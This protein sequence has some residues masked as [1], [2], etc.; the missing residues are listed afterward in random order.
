[1]L[2]CETYCKRAGKLVLTEGEWEKEATRK[3]R[4]RF[5]WGFMTTFPELAN[6]NRGDWVSY[7]VTLA[8]V[9]Y[10]VVG[11]NI[12]LGIQKGGGR[13]AYGIYNMAGGGEERGGGAGER[14]GYK[15]KTA[16]RKKRGR[17]STPTK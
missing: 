15:K 13:S 2:D 17:Q 6:Y 1:G 16:E 14:G 9:T 7:P 3:E 12:R 8:P 10:G 5:P 4:S 11:L